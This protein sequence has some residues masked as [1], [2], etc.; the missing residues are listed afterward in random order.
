MSEFITYAVLKLGFSF[1][2]MEVLLWM[3]NN[4]A[5]KICFVEKRDPEELLDFILEREDQ[6]CFIEKATQTPFFVSED[7]DKPI[8]VISD[9]E[10]W[11]SNLRWYAPGERAPNKYYETNPIEIAGVSPERVHLGG[12]PIPVKLIYQYELIYL[13]SDK[14]HIGHIT[15]LFSEKFEFGKKPNSKNYSSFLKNLSITELKDN[16][17]SWS[18]I[19][20]LQVWGGTFWD[21]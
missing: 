6:V 13:F 7:H 1:E 19:Q 16:I 5:P 8:L 12:P 4:P 18:S 14:L 21:E 10:E 3:A 15:F 11:L 2:I 17:P 9:S 20:T